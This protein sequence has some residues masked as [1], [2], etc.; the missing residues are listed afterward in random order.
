[1]DNDPA[2]ALVALQKALSDYHQAAVT[3]RD[4]DSAAVIAAEG[5]LQDA[6]FLYD[7]ALD[8]ATGVPL[9]FLLVDDEGEDD[10]DPQYRSAVARARE[11][12]GGQLRDLDELGGDETDEDEETGL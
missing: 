12:F 10:A 4:P 1:M 2:A 8:E 7:A 9:P 5:P 11:A 6:F 3:S